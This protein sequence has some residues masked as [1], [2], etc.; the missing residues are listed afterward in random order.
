MGCLKDFIWTNEATGLKSWIADWEDH[1]VL[2]ASLLA[3]K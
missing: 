3:T 1:W 2:S